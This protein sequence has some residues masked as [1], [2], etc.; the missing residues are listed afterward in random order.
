MLELNLEAVNVLCQLRTVV[1]NFFKKSKQRILNNLL[2]VPKWLSSIVSTG[3]LTFFVRI[4]RNDNM[5]KLG[6]CSEKTTL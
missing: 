6:S 4:Q 1:V 5:E 2:G 3:I